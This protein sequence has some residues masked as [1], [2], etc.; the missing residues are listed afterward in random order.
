METIDDYGEL[1]ASIWSFIGRLL[2][3]GGTRAV[4]ARSLQFAALE[5]PLLEK[6]QV[7]D[8]E[9]DF[10]GLRDYAAHGG[11]NT[12]QTLDA[13][14]LLTVTIFKILSNLSENAI[15]GPLLTQLD[16]EK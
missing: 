1:T 9:V 13:L 6:V 15:T 7:C 14:I 5:A 16:K 12:S 4:L 2:G 11:C 10:S 8:R 3:E